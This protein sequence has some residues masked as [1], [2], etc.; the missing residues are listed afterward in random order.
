MYRKHNVSLN[1]LPLIIAF[2]LYFSQAKYQYAI[3]RQQVSEFDFIVQT[4][5][6]ELK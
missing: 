4:F 2:K 1:V 3:L 5:N 6:K